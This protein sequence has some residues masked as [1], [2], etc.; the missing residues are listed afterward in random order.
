MPS[1]FIKVDFVVCLGCAIQMKFTSVAVG[2]LWSYFNLSQ[3]AML[4]G[5][6]FNKWYFLAMF[7]GKQLN[8]F[9][10]IT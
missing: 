2:P 8:E 6:A 3:L 9:L 7:S 5:L 4:R 1:S 10:L